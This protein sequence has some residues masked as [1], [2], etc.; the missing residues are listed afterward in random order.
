MCD[1]QALRYCSWVIQKTVKAIIGELAKLARKIGHGRLKRFH[2]LWESM[3][4]CNG[5]T[6]AALRLCAYNQRSE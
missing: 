5:D 3:H 1:F 2:R 4:F 6:F